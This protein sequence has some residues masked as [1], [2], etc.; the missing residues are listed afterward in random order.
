MDAQYFNACNNVLEPPDLFL[1]FGQCVFVSIVLLI[2]LH[3]ELYLTIRESE[4]LT[5]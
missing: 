1:L 2:H 5:S 4:F 3:Q